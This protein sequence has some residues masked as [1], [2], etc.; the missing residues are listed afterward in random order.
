MKKMKA[1][2]LSFLTLSV[3]FFACGGLARAKTASA[4]NVNPPAQ[5]ESLLFPTSY[6]QYLA[7]NS[8][9]SVAVK[10]NYTAISD[11]NVLYLCDRTGS[12]P[13]WKKYEHTSNITKIQFGGENTL[14]FLSHTN[15]T[16]YSIDVSLWG[17]EAP[18]PTQTSVVCTT[19]TIKSGTL[20]YSNTSD[21]KTTLYTAPLSDFSAFEQIYESDVYSPSIDVDGKG[22]VYFMYG[23]NY[24]WKLSLETRIPIQV[25]QLPPSTSR[26]LLIDGKLF[27]STET[28]DF[29]GYSIAELTEKG[30]SSKCTPFAEHHGGY[31]AMSVYGSNLYIVKN[32]TVREYS[33][34]DNGFTAYEIGA[35][36]TSTHRLNG[37]SEVHLYGD[38]LFIADDDNDRISVYN[39]KTATFETPISTNLNTPHLA[40]DEDTLLVASGATAIL[41][42]LR[43]ENYGSALSTLDTT[44]GGAIIGATCVYGSYYVAT[45]NDCYTPVWTETEYAWTEYSRTFHYGTDKLTSGADGGLYSLYNG[46]VYR[47]EEKEFLDETEEHGAPYWTGLPLTVSKIAVDY[48][49]NLYALANNEIHVYSKPDDEGAFTAKTHTLNTPFVYSSETP[50]ALS[51]TFGVEENEVYILYERDY[52]ILSP[53]YDLPT[54]QTIKTENAHAEIFGAQTTFKVVETQANTTF[55]EFDIKKLSSTSEYFPYTRFYRQET[56]LTAVEITQTGHYS[57]LAYRENSTDSYRVFLAPTA[58]VREKT[59]HAL[60]Y[61][62]AKLG[63]VVSDVGFY[64]YPSMGVPTDGTIARA[65]KVSLLGEVNGLDCDYYEIEYEGKKGYIPKQFITLFNGAPSAVD[66]V[67]VGDPKKDDDTVWR[68][69]YILLG[70]AAIGIL[71]DL[72]ILRKKED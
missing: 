33:I 14:Y 1:T 71:V 17:S 50:N 2:I 3:A 66:T 37:S 40:A 10:K 42:S 48:A 25:A 72:L 8:P 18:T 56:P 58:R 13:V 30:D 55:V 20:Y 57:V 31:S 9:N 45:N 54:M 65:E 49:G 27:C 7:L 44:D 36:S 34:P 59:E 28:K 16:L 47:Y 35:S 32:N 53:L 41:Y 21:G 11:G 62:T 12:A 4:E 6:D 63:H 19:F 43:P 5:T 68:L 29:Y 15:S 38:R 22:A 46:T 69:T 39:H 52:A 24:L 61:G 70:T 60:T 64:Q 51:F 23:S 26:I 67:V